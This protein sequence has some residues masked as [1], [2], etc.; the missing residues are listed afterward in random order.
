VLLENP[1]LLL[2]AC[3]SQNGDALAKAQPPHQESVAD[4]DADMEDVREE[5]DDEY[6]DGVAGDSLDEEEDV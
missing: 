4:E 5:Y 3:S 6:G 1:C 2:K